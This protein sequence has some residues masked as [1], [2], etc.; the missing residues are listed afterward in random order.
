MR[1]SGAVGTE[2]VTPI[3]VPRENDTARRPRQRDAHLRIPHLTTALTN[4]LMFL[5]IE[6]G[7]SM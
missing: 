7:R 5:G 1:K 3:E 4:P 2:R 6:L